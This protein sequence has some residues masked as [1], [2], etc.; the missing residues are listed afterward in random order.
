[1]TPIV[2]ETYNNNQGRTTTTYK[3]LN[4]TN[5]SIVDIRWY[6]FYY[7]QNALFYDAFKSA[8]TGVYI[9]YN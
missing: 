3:Q 6:T 8:I 9:L 4:C 7:K 1:M 2:H 5:T